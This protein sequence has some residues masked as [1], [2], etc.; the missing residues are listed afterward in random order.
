MASTTP[1]VYIDTTIL[2]GK[3]P[4]GTAPAG[5][6]FVSGV[7][8][9]GPVDAAYRVTSVN[10]FQ[11]RFGDHVSYGVLFDQVKT[12]FEEGGL[13]A[14]VVRL[15]GTTPTKGTHSF[16]DRAGSPLATLKIEAQNAGA[17]SSAVEVQ[18]TNG[19]AANTVR[20]L[21]FLKNVLV[22]STPD[23]NDPSV[24][25]ASINASAVASKLVVATDLDSAT[26][27]P[28]NNPAV[29]ARTALS[30][31]TDDRGTINTAAYIA[32][33][34]KFDASLGSGAVAVPG[35]SGQTIWGPLAEHAA[36]TNRIAL[37]SFASGNTAAQSVTD[38][39]TLV[40]TY[41]EFV[42]FY[43]PHINISDG[44]GGLLPISPEGYVAGVRAKAHVDEG[45]WRAFAGEISIGQSVLSPVREV[46]SVDAETLQSARINPIR[47]IANTTRIYGALSASTDTNNWNFITLRDT[48]N[49]IVVQ[50]QERLEPFLF[51]TI[52]NRHLFFSKIQG[53]LIALCEPIRT[54]GGLYEMRGASDQLV[55]P[56]YSVSVTD[57]M[58][59]PDQV[60]LGILNAKLAVRVS[61]VGQRINL[62]ITKSAITASV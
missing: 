50:A 23:C 31:G 5:T 10:D 49:Y 8:E 56:G 35:Q 59:P 22:F 15:V 4:E 45:P 41:P 27:S 53:S 28:N 1:G 52:D 51:V 60:A 24:A 2:Q 42:G 7:S 44:V 36:V 20:V 47:V 48:I 16:L 18:I 55:D 38:V 13:I 11:S 9:R 39:A 33:L 30:A 6:F 34:L 57:E 25:A 37:L 19:N 21:I 26:A 40:T 29:I 17:W 46:G 61:A 12:Y 54:A 62:A 32:S 3:S 58:N 43:Y 14:Y